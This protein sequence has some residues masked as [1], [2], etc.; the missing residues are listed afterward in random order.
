MPRFVRW[1]LAVQGVLY[2]VTGLWPLAHMPSFEAVTGPKTDDW[3]VF[4]VGL[5]LAVI[6]AVALASVVR[7]VIDPLVV[8]LASG[9]ALSL[10]AIEIVFVL[11]KTISPI[12]LADAVVELLLAGALLI[13]L[14][15]SAGLKSP[16]DG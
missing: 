9:A 11:N 12:Y 14:K 8:M 2:V 5:L 16:A 1:V 6:G 13:G 15:R 3:L 10:A 4:T 7:R